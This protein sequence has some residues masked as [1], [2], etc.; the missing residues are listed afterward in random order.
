MIV[1]IVASGRARDARTRVR[2]VEHAA[3]PESS[4]TRRTRHV[5]GL[6]LH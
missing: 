3:E 6:L 5:A 2:G 1:V 4:V